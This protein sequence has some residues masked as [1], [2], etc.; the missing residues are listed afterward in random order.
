[1][2]RTQYNKN[3]TVSND[4]VQ[5]AITVQDVFLC[6]SLEQ[7][8]RSVLHKHLWYGVGLT[9]YRIEWPVL[10]KWLRY[11]VVKSACLD[12]WRDLCAYRRL[13]SC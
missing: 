5:P 12:D 10:L 6:L 7:R 8:N 13:T 9:F 4:G 1:M 3:T 2:I 11:N